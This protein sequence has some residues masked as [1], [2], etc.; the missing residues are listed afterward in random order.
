MSRHA[1]IACLVILGLIF[2]VN[3]K[4]ELP[5][6]MRN[7]R[8]N[9]E[10]FS[11][12]FIEEIKTDS[13]NDICSTPLSPGESFSHDVTQNITSGYLNIGNGN[14]TA[15]SLFFLFYKCR[16]LN[17]SVNPTATGDFTSVPVVIWLQ[18]GKK[19]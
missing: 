14:A 15:S 7:R 1:Q 16:G 2:A 8:D 6:T 5:S 13:P 18:G 4:L 10:D 9:S 11:K 17:S 12:D 19:S 3:S